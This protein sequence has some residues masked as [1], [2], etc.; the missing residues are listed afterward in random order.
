MPSL[1]QVQLLG[2]PVFSWQQQDV[3][4][5]S[6]K[7][8]A[9][10]AYLCTQATPASRE[11]LAELLWGVGKLN[12]VRQAL[13]EL[14]QLPGASDW[15][16]DDN[17]SVHVKAST[18]LNA[19]ETALNQENYQQALELCSGV[20]CEG[21]R[22]GNAPAFM[23]WL[24]VERL[25]FEE[26]YRQALEKQVEVLQRQQ[27]FDE[28][29]G[30]ARQLLEL[31][32]LNE[33][34]HRVVIALE[35][36][37]GHTELALE[38]FERCRVLLRDELGVEPLPETLALLRTI[39][40]GGE[41]HAMRAMQLRAGESIPGLTEKFFGRADSI[42]QTLEWLL[43]G[44]RVLLHGFGGSGKSALAAQVIAGFLGVHASGVLWLELGNES[45]EFA[46]EA[47][48]RAL[49]AQQ[50]MAQSHAATQ[51]QVLHDLLR[52]HNVKLLVLDDVWNAYSL[53]KLTEVLPADVA[54]LVTSRQR[55]PQLKRVSV[56]RLDRQAALE[57]L[58]FHAGSAVD[59]AQGDLLCQLLG[60]HAFAVRIAGVTLREEKLS[61]RELSRRIKRAPHLLSLPDVL[62]GDEQRSI[63]SLLQVSLDALDDQAYESF[64]GFGGMFAPVVSPDLLAL[65]LRRDINAVET[66]LFT[67]VQ[68]GL[69]EFVSQ[70]GSDAIAF[71]VHD[72]AHSYARSR[73]PL[74]YQTT[75]QATK[76]YVEQHQ[77]NTAAIDIELA[78][79][80]GA[81]N[82]ANDTDVIS[83]M[84]RLFTEGGYFS[85]RGHSLQ[86]TR[87]LSRAAEAARNQEQL[88]FAHFLFAKLGDAEFNFFQNY[89]LAL[90]HYETALALARQTDN[91]QREAVYLSLVGLS[92]AQLHDPEA[93]SILDEAYA[94]AKAQGDVLTVCTIL[95]HRGYTAGV[96]GDA[97]TA[98]QLF[99]EALRQLESLQ[100]NEV[101]ASELNR[102][103]FFALLNKGKSELD[104]ARYDASI[105]LRERAL[106]LATEQK[107][108]LWIAYCHAE[109][110]ETYHTQQ[111]R[112][113]AQTHFLTALE[114]YEQCQA[115][116]D[117]S[118]LREFLM[119]QAYELT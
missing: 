111:L 56:G 109:L 6:R 42:T 2:V 68:R 31:D 53:S 10:L 1:L 43:A 72:L 25:R 40:Q 63:A 100:E 119:A 12:N 114:L 5:S 64:L 87:L 113:K 57:L 17:D 98:N 44:E 62:Q 4:P 37:R 65:A 107:N 79:I 38:Q 94:L 58:A 73:S 101:S 89:A 74:R 92:R 22:V 28:A 86:T 26:L 15:L 48:A 108:T 105:A 76:T 59:A 3:C 81:A 93:E 117:A 54:L 18:D 46:F 24:E 106:A 88:E 112:Q 9:L 115:R 85:A 14:R 34:A 77:H 84:M 78:N 21:V 29:L 67:L 95:D 55:Y 36:A 97:V 96:S 60:D 118:A 51:G 66:S 69:A 104:L 39:E 8:Q 116:Q 30:L 71:R 110:G 27:Q 91:A 13:Y 11:H 32:A 50:R 19:F 80:L 99:S 35:H 23:D 83:I 61:A 82:A 16:F 102:R 103:M 20:L 90:Q 47:I 45:P 7:A 49:D 70:A 75:V 52:E 33:S 41:S